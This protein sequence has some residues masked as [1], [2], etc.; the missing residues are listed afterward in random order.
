M[1]TMM[2]ADQCKETPNPLHTDDDDDAG[3]SMHKKRHMHTQM[4]M[5][6]DARSAHF[7]TKQPM[8]QD[9][10]CA[11]AIDPLSFAIELPYADQI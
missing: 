1:M 5:Q 7:R 6:T 4:M 2:Q 3:R 8:P 9:E 10:L 11:D